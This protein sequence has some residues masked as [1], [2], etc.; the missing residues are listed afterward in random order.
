METTAKSQPQT[1]L[2][3][4]VKCRRGQEIPSDARRPGQAL[5]DDLTGLDRPEGVRITAVECLQNCD[6]GCTVA[7]RGGDAKWTYVF[8]HVD[9]AS[10]PE[11]ILTGAAQYH[12]SADGVIPWRQRPEH[13]KRNCIA[14][15]PPVALPEEA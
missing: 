5:Y 1:E 4:C 3:V 6:H 11:M 15:I 7:L 12:S 14:R 10:H 9:E 2:L 8:G 13:F